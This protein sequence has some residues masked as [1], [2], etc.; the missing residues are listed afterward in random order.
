[1]IYLGSGPSIGHRV[2]ALLRPALEKCG[3]TALPQGLDVDKS[4]SMQ[5]FSR[6]RYEDEDVPENERP[7]FVNAN[8]TSLPFEDKTVERIE[9]ASLVTTPEEKRTQMIREMNRI[10]KVGG[11]AALLTN[12]HH[13]TEGFRRSLK[14]MGF[15]IVEH[16]PIELTDVQKTQLRE[17]VDNRKMTA[18]DY[19]RILEKINT[20]GEFVLAIKEHDV[21]LLMP[22]DLDWTLTSQE[23]VPS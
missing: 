5:A 15:R 6:L 20:G 13:F 10:L 16:R 19:R 18:E 3:I 12:A 21:P 17:L 9:N 1:V 22:T 4:F 2:W 8:M 14:K 11:M 7:K 23:S